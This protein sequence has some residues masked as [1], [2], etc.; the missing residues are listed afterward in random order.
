MRKGK[1]V[2]WSTTNNTRTLTY[3]GYILKAVED[4]YH[5]FC[6]KLYDKNGNYLKTYDSVCR[7]NRTTAR[8]YVDKLERNKYNL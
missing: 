3:R 5:G 2:M 1:K 6:Y 8:D 4:D 7:G